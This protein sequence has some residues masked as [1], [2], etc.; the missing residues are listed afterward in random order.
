MNERRKK[1][2]KTKLERALDEK[3]QQTKQKRLAI[4]DLFKTTIRS[5]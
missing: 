2:I 4:L 5:C 3:P 1:I